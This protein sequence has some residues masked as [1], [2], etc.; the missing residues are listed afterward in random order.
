MWQF[1]HKYIYIIIELYNYI[2]IC[3]IPEIN[4]FDNPHVK[5]YF[6]KQSHAQMRI[7]LDYNQQ[8]ISIYV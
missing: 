6:F 4:V 2:Y 1:A 8:I 7:Q 3:G 5:L